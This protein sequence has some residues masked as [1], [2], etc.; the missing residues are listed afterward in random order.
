[1]RTLT[2]LAVSALVVAGCS[3]SPARPAHRLAEGV[4]VP[5]TPTPAATTTSSTT[6]TTW[7]DGTE[8]RGTVTV[9]AGSVVTL[10]PGARVRAAD[11]ARLVVR[12]TLR[13]PSGGALTG[14][15][16]Q[17]LVVARGGSAELTGVTLRG[18]DTALTTETGAGPVALTRSTVE[19]VSSPLS[20]AAGTTTTLTD[21]AVRKVHGVALVKGVLVADRL[22]YDKAGLEGIV[23]TGPAAALRLTDSRLY[24]NGQYEGDMITTSDAGE[25]TMSGTSVVGAHCAFH[26]VGVGRLTLDRLSIHGNAY[27]FMAYGSAPGAVHRI[28]DTDVYDNRDF[29]LEET[30]GVEQGQI[31]VDGGFWGRNGQTPAATITQVSGKVVRTHPVAAPAQSR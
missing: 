17:G 11:G 19:D 23:A 30:P 26:L 27:G 6:G 22:S 9:P 21:V 20:L 16:W 3:G 18:A 14:S 13:A 31:L 28:T 15:R 12:G 7:P 1:M 2:V 25:V 10:A 4:Y 5:G 24:G 29:G 8:L